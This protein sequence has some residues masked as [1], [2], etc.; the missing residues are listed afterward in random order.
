MKLIWFSSAPWV[1]TGYGVQTR[2]ILQRLKNEGHDIVCATKHPIGSWMQYEGIDVFTGLSPTLMDEYIER[3]DVD[4]IL[5]L[6]DPWRQGETFTRWVSLTPVD[7]ERVSP[8][9]L[10][11]IVKAEVRVAISQHGKREIE[12]ADLPC[13]YVP[14]G[15]D[16]HNDYYPSGEG[17]D[18]W[19]RACKIDSSTFVVGTVG[20]HYGNNRKGFLEL[21]KGFAMFNK[22]VP[23]SVLHL[24]TCNSDNN[25]VLFLSNVAA[26]ENIAERVL[27]V[28]NL[29]Y[30]LE[31]ITTKQMR[32][33]YN[34]I[35]VF[36]LPTRGEGFGLPIIEAQACGTPV[37]TTNTTTGPE[38]VPDGCGWLIGVN[39]DDA[40]W[41][42]LNSYRYR[43]KPSMIAERMMHAYQEWKQ[44]DYK[45]MQLNAVANAW[46]YNWENIWISHYK[47]LLNKLEQRLKSRSKENDESK[48]QE[49]I[50]T[51]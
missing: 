7:T 5:S 50:R 44:G 43:A 27:F 20:A 10:S 32:D 4:Y 26:C 15:L 46:H 51:V 29:P 41:V 16:C 19:R 38:L 18:E 14:L 23:N 31:N 47:P 33:M 45:T 17:R 28:P 39:E 12:N 8:M 36:C 21:I 34:G 2:V 35:D 40:M 3:E 9:I 37:I 42:G 11:N 6:F 49:T 25:H 24:H 1:T 48:V 22:K 13:E 30:M